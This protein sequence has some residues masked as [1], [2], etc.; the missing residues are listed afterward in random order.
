VVT[1]LIQGKY[2][3]NLLRRVNTKVLT[4]PIV[5]EGKLIPLGHG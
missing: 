2:V 3:Q 4:K 1:R 5:S